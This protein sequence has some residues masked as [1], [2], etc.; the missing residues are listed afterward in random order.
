M[1]TAAGLVAEA[2]HQMVVDHAGGLH[3]G[4]D[5]GRAD[6]LNPRAPSSLEI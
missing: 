5:D 6:D 4:V 2:R 1:L 3:E